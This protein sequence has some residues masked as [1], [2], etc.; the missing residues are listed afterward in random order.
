MYD[1]L[2]RFVL[3]LGHPQKH[4]TLLLLP[5]RHG[6]RPHERQP[7]KKQVAQLRQPAFG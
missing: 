5:E 4:F 6:G 2:K 1:S 3:L 7:V